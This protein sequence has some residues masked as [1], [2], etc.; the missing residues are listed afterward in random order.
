[1]HPQKQRPCHLT[2][3][4]ALIVV[5]CGLKPTSSSPEEH[6][7]ECPS[8]TIVHRVAID[9][10]ALQVPEMPGYVMRAR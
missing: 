2:K 1:M 8:R 6:F 3:L 5:P 9:A 4:E 7:H 10:K